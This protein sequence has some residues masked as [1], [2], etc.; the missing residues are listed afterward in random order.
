[1]RAKMVEKS[2]FQHHA[3]VDP[4]HYFHH[5]Y[6]RL[7]PVDGRLIPNIVVIQVLLTHYPIIVQ[8][9]VEHLCV[10]VL[11]VSASRQSVL[12]MGSLGQ[13]AKTLE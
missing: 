5:L 9:L 11:Q 6:L 8:E 1:M 7:P 2:Q 4:G 10:K 13:E 12:G 3:N